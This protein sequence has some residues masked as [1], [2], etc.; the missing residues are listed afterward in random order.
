MCGI[1]GFITEETKFGE[2]ARS[3]FLRQGLIVD[4]LRGDDSTGAFGVGHEPMFKDETDLGATWC[5][6]VSEGYEFVNS[7]SYIESFWDVSPYRSCVGHN[8]AATMGAIDSEGAHPFIVG[9][10]T[11]VHNGTL[12]STHGLPI[13]MYK[14]KDINIDSH[15][16]AAN[17]AEHSVEEVIKEL[18]GAFTLVWHDARDSSMN[19]IRNTK[20]PLH[21]AKAA[22]QK[23]LFFASEG[24]MLDFLGKRLGLDL[25]PI[26]YPKEGQH[27]KWL[28]ETPLESP[29]VKELDLRAEW[30]SYNNG[31]TALGGYS[32]DDDY[33]DWRTEGARRQG[34]VVI[35][36][37]DRVF[38][39]G[40]KKAVPMLMQ[41]ELLK[42]DMVVE[43]RL[44][45]APRVS[46]SI[47]ESRK[48]VYGMLSATYKAVIFSVLDT[49]ATQMERGWTVRPIAVYVKPSGE[50]TIIV[51]LV[52]NLWVNPSLGTSSGSTGTTLD[53]NGRILGYEKDSNGNDKRYK[54]AF[55]I[56]YSASEW[57]QLVMD[58]CG[59]CTRSLE[60]QDADDVVW[61]NNGAQPLCCYCNDEAFGGSQ[62]DEDIPFDEVDKTDK[63]LD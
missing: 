40:R 2:D 4:T 14:M 49:T 19:I 39:G 55:G 63:E 41:E 37:D 8:R 31:Y 33:D 10:I 24:P 26:Y 60:I 11:L 23:T 62:I 5:K 45:F 42:Y 48:Q 27:L 58:G 38:V 1:V 36:G 47:G 30:S 54:G 44:H 9:P 17:L 57:M 59:F 20:R 51:K 15:A 13:P 52:N 50:P 46:T 43:D 7:D 35:H 21:M 28:P 61:I 32:W 25:G 16:I 3:K 53:Q 29:Q 12:N 56:L 18:D 34:N 6:A 22:K